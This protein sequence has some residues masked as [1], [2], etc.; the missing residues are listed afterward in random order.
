[1][2]SIRSDLVLQFVGDGR[3]T[4]DAE[5]P[6]AGLSQRGAGRAMTILGEGAAEPEAPASSVGDAEARKLRLD[7]D[8]QDDGHRG[9][10]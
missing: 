7:Y 4:V 10:R 3:G 8:E 2:T 1:M 5:L 9:F 6:V